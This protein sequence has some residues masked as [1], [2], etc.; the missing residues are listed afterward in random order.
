MLTCV[1]LPIARIDGE[2]YIG[3]WRADQK[4]GLGTYVW[5]PG[6]G[7]VAGD[8]Y[9][10]QFKEVISFPSKDKS[11]LHIKYF[12]LLPSSLYNHPYCDYELQ[13]AHTSEIIPHCRALRL[14]WAALRLLIVAI[15]R[16]DI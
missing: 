15:T 4:H 16:G 6:S 12:Y 9:E 3:L 13:Q 11:I 8:K 14:A 7:D 5:G 2:H 1:Q 10:G